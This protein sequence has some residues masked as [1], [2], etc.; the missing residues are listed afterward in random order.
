[1]EEQAVKKIPFACQLYSVRNSLAKDFEGTIRAVKEAGYEGIEFYGGLSTWTADRINAI[2]AETGLKVCGWH[3][4]ITD[5]DPENIKNTIAFHKSIGNN[6]MVIPGLPGEMTA[7]A[8]A[9]H[10]TAQRF[11]EI[12]KVLREE[13]MYTGY[14]NHYIEFALIDGEMPW[15]ILG[16]ETDKDFILQIDN[17][18]AMHGKADPLEYL[19][20]YPGRA[21]TFHFKPYSYTKGYDVTPGVDDDV[22]WQETV[23][24]LIRQNATEWIIAEY[25]TE[26]LYTDIEGVQICAKNLGK[27]LEK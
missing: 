20:K 7:S 14:H 12:T 21:R 23:D 1:M 19:K 17:G 11:N 10:K 9:W 4:A 24:E 18:N 5:F 3:S 27:F 2:T 6:C 26:A 8:A 22:P 13:G 15:D 25:E 16:E